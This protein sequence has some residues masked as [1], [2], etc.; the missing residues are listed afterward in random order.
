MTKKCAGSATECRAAMLGILGTDLRTNCACKGTDL[1]Q[2]HKCLGW[3]RL[4]WVNPCVGGYSRFYLARKI[5]NQVENIGRT[6]KTFS[7]NFSGISERFSYA[8]SSWEII[9]DNIG[10]YTTNNF[11]VSKKHN[12]LHRRTYNRY[13]SY[14]SFSSNKR[15]H[16]GAVYAAASTYTSNNHNFNDDYNYHNYHGYYNTCSK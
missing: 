10:S 9:A 2:I 8:K 15:K 14:T 6:L 1:T 3:H 13:D 12:Q 4:L 7:L 16:R 5:K 11:M